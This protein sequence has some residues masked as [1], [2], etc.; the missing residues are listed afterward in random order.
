MTEDCQAPKEMPS[1]I[2]VKI[3]RAK[4][5]P[6]P[7]GGMGKYKEGDEGYIVE[8]ED[9]YR[10]WSPKDVF[11]AAYRSTSGMTFG[12]AIEA[13]KKGHRVSRV[14]W[15][16]KNMFVYFVGGSNPRVTEMRGNAAKAVEVRSKLTNGAAAHQSI[17]PHIDFMTADGSI[18]VGWLASQTD[19]LADDWQI[20]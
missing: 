8:Y 7:A 15:N 19:M 10:S 16:G 2:G 6:C 13:M 18:V 9:G 4:P 5:G 17:C 12:L 14:G 11:Y 3:I 1:Y 20:V